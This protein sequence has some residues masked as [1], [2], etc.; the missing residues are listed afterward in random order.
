MDFKRYVAA[1]IAA[2]ISLHLISESA[3]A[4]KLPLAES[5]I[6]RPVTTDFGVDHFH[7]ELL[8]FEKKL[9][10]ADDNSY[11]NGQ[12]TLYE[13]FD[14]VENNPFHMDPDN[15]VSF[16]ALLIP[17]IE[18]G[19]RFN[20]RTLSRAGFY[21][22]VGL[23]TDDRSFL[24]NTGVMM[25]TGPVLLKA[26]VFRAQIHHEASHLDYAEP[27]YDELR[28]VSYITVGLSPTFGF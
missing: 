20:S 28:A 19:R 24:L 13:R 5:S 22:T 9:L 2:L 7:M 23:F 25:Q 3:Y 11:V 6:F 27:A 4:E 26:G 16:E 8:T 10:C 12:V 18:I 1:T 21:G 15:D 17:G 14:L